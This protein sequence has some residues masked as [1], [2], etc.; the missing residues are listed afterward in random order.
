M[1][2]PFDNIPEIQSA[3]GLD[4]Y[5]YFSFTA[6]FFQF[7]W[8]ASFTSVTYYCRTEIDAQVGPPF[9]VAYSYRLK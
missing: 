4:Y 6:N 1:I 5:A 9:I 8:Q 2:S 3:F 7:K